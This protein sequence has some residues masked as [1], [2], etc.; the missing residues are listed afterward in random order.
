MKRAMPRSDD[1]EDDTSSNDSS[2]LDTDTNDYLGPTKNKFSQ[3]ESAM[4]K[5]KGVYFEALSRHGYNGRLS[6]LK[7]P[8]PKEPDQ[9]QNW[10]WSSGKETREKEKEETYEDCT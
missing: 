10:S 2:T 6:V 7:V 8:P 4:R 1:E 3:A 5:S 9:E